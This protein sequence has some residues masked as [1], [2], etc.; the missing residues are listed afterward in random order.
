MIAYK[1]DDRICLQKTSNV[2]VQNDKLESKLQKNFT[3][4][5]RSKMQTTA[6]C[7]LTCVF[8]SHK[9]TNDFFSIFC[10]ILGLNDASISYSS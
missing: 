5:A 9:K 1:T 7:V 2:Y 6:T 4:S 10:S 8:L 3:G